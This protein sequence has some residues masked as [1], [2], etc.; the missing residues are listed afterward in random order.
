MPSLQDVEGHLDQ[1][2][3]EMRSRPMASAA[4]KREILQLYKRYKRRLGRPHRSL[5]EEGLRESVLEALHD[6]YSQVQDGKKL[7]SLRDA[8]KLALDE[9]PYCGFGPIEDLDHHL[10]KALYRHFSIF[11]LN[12]VPCCATCNRIKSRRPPPTRDKQLLN[13]YLEDPTSATFFR[14]SVAMDPVRGGVLVEFRVVRV[15]GMRPQLVSRLN[16]HLEEYQLSRRLRAPVNTYLAGIAVS[17]EDNMNQGGAAAVRDFLQ[18]SAVVNAARFGKNSWR[19]AL[20]KGLARS[21]DFCNGG[22]RS[23]LGL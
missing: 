3:D 12:L 2:L 23:A 6:G 15:R 1:I 9:C 16:A 19:T 11:P 7:S 22:F 4:E 5:S 10:Q 17:L 21:R 20:L 13:A 8:L 18:R 14:A